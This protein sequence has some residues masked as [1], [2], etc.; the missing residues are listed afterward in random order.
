[1]PVDAVLFANTFEK[2]NMIH[3]VVFI[4]RWVLLFLNRV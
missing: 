1:M 4:K 3:P 2:R